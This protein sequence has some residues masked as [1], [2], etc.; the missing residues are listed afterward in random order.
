MIIRCSECG[1]QYRVD[2]GRLSDQTQVFRCSH[3]GKFLRPP[4]SPEKP[5]TTTAND[6]AY[7]S[8]RCPGCETAYRVNPQRLSGKKSGLRCR[9][10]D[11]VIPLPP[12]QPNRSPKVAVIRTDLS[13][14]TSPA[15]D[16]PVFETYVAEPN[17][18]KKRR[19]LLAGTAAVLLAL[20]VTGAIFGKSYW[21][22]IR[23]VVGGIETP[24]SQP[25]PTN[26]DN[27]HQPLIVLET[28]LPMLHRELQ[29]RLPLLTD[30]PRWR[31]TAA[32]IKTAR[33]RQAK[34]FLYADAK[35]QIL[36]VVVLQGGEAEDLKAAMLRMGQLDYF[37]LP[38]EGKAYRFNRE[39]LQIASRSG[40]P[41]DAY[42]VWF[43]PGWL[44]CAPVSQSQLWKEGKQHW[45]SFSVVQFAE[46]L[47][48]PIRLASLAVR[49]P[50][51][52][53]QG[54]TRSLIPDS[55][56]QS[57]PASVQA[58]DAAAGFLSL[59]ERSL[60]QI[61]SMAGLFRF[62]G[63]NGR[64]LQYAQQF[65]SGVDSTPIFI[66]LQSEN[67]HH[68]RTSVSAIFSKLL[69]HDRLNSSVELSENQLTVIARWQAED[70]QALL[71]ALIETIF[72]PER[73]DS[74][75]DSLPPGKS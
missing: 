68:D 42:R 7:I 33:L 10:C 22:Q 15:A 62:D 52:L 30:D 36:P 41:A 17:I 35:H 69:H 6:P 31:F 20:I 26:T 28:D 9:N 73:S 60:R 66:R 59:L 71:Q 23:S 47:G 21:Q 1:V 53:P 38:A 37:L 11:Q 65:R 51:D 4:P 2:A 56:P 5:P 55:L 3:C 29:T 18:R 39:I 40:F 19:F 8:I 34:L 70:D 50:Q 44:V 64:Q 12:R 24:R 46:T 16:Q 14:G 67:N 25:A 75:A 27:G 49:V 54:W 13:Q 48:K 57:D 72:G 61:D 45:R 63:K 74:A 58:L 43:H 32:V